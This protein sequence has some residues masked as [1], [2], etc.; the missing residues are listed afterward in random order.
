MEINFSFHWLC[1]LLEN[2]SRKRSSSTQK[3]KSVQSLNVSKIERNKFVGFLD[4]G[5]FNFSSMM[6]RKEKEFK[7][8]LNLSTG[9]ALKC[10]FRYCI[11]SINW[12]FES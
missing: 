7:E 2:S 6:V 9:R 10:L 12:F 4:K 1:Q 5:K 11:K 3:F 8:G